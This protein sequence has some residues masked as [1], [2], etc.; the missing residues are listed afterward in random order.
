MK[1]IILWKYERASWQWD[2]LC[3]LIMCFIFLTPNSWFEKRE[4]TQTPRSAVKTEGISPK[5]NESKNG[6]LEAQKREQTQA[7]NLASN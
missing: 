5:N 3:V 7:R 6:T 2:V 1:D 4:A